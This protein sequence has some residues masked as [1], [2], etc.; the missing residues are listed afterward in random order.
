MKRMIIGLLIPLVG[1]VSNEGIPVSVPPLPAAGNS[2][3]V[4]RPVSPAQKPLAPVRPMPMIEN[5]DAET[6]EDTQ[7]VWATNEAEA[8]A[9]CEQ[10]AQNRTQEGGT[11]VTVQGKPQ[12]MTMNPSRN[13][14]Y[15]FTCRFRIEL[16]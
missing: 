14:T 5:P 10:I 11:L 13:G 7:E 15:R 2:A 16:Q 3:P 6:E 9:K 8:A 1:C 4:S 12:R